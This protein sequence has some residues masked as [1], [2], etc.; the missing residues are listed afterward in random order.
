MDWII[1]IGNRTRSDDGLGPRVA[2]E[3]EPGPNVATCTVPQLT[4]EMGLDLRDADRV[5][6][7]DTSLDETGVDLRRLEPRPLR[8]LGHSISPEGLLDLMRT[9]YG[10]TPEGWLLTVAGERFDVGDGLSAEAEARL[11]EARRRVAE[12][13]ADEGGEVA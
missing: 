7:V 13:V 11:P 12:W 2:E 4:P 9:A 5:L 3:V 10:A 6:F 8:G 1:G